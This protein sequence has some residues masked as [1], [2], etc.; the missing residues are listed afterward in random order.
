[1]ATNINTSGR[2]AATIRRL[3]V[4]RESVDTLFDRLRFTLDTAP[5]LDYQP[6]PWLGKSASRRATGTESRW[7][8]LEDVIHMAPP[9]SALD[10]GANVGWFSIM[11]AKRGIPTLA[12]ER[13]PKYYRILTYARQRLAVQHLGIQISDL[14]LST[15]ALLPVADL[16]LFLSVWHHVVRANG[17]DD[18]RRF[19]STVWAHTQCVLMFE[20][21]EDE[22]PDYF[23]MPTLTPSPKEAIEDILREACTGA[24][25]VDLGLHNA[26]AP[27]GRPCERHLFGVFRDTVPLTPPVAQDN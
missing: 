16:V 3:G 23:G 18:A 13:E 7:R 24:T 2:V 25:V 5:T 14:S 15:L 4:R 17:L 11:L 6:L 27:D 1:M 26:F 20:T 9:T 22:L 21:G 12:V 8:A 10:I 19:L